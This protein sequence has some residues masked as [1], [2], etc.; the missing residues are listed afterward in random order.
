M[1][2]ESHE[3]LINKKH[4]TKYK[5]AKFVIGAFYVSIFLAILYFG[6]IDSK[7]VASLWVFASAIIF[8]LQNFV[9]SAVA[10]FYIKWASEYEV[11]DI[12]KTWNPFVLSIWEVKEIGLFFTKLREVD[13]NDLTFTWKTISFPNNLIFTF[14]I[15]N[16]TK[17]NLLFWYHFNITLTCRLRDIDTLLQNFEKIVNDTYQ[18]HLSQ[19]VYTKSARKPNQKPTFQYNITNNGLEVKVRLMVH[20][21]QVFNLN[22][23]IMKSLVRGHNQNLIELYSEKD[24]MRSE[25]KSNEKVEKTEKSI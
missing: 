13:E 21:Y 7:I 3:Q 17:N 12:I 16:Y 10:H 22:N 8:A 24:Y 19:N 25:K 2:L 23:E 15:F 20:F 6:L 9:A 18:N 1:S 5:L 11:W 4:T 14:W